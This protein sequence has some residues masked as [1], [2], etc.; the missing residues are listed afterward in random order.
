VKCPRGIDIAR[1]ME[2]LRQQVLRRSENYLEPSALSREAIAEM[3]QIA[4]V[5]GFRKFTS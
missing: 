1:V 2:A 3:P 4:L 5:A